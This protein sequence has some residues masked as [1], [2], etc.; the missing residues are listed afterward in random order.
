M[1]TSLII[2]MGIRGSIVRDLM[3]LGLIIKLGLGIMVGKE[4]GL[5]GIKVALIIIKEDSIIK[6]DSTIIREGSTAREDSIIVKEDSIR[7]GSIIIREGSIIKGDSII[8]KGLGQEETREDSIIK[9]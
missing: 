2:I 8:I 9:I 5:G 4:L 3:A 1:G 6:G 7:E